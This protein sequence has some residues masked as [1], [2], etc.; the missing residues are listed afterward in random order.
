MKLA[1]QAI[2]DET[3]DAL[4]TRVRWYV[5]RHYEVPRRTA[6]AFN[7]FADVLGKPNEQPFKRLPL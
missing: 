7:Y 2:L 1:T 3:L 5:S 6:V 4:L